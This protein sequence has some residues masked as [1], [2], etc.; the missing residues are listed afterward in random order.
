MRISERNA[1]WWAQHHSIPQAIEWQAIVY[2]QLR[3]IPLMPESYSLAPENSKFQYELRQKN[4]G[5]GVGG[6]RR[7]LQREVDEIHV[8]TIR[9]GSQRALRQEDLSLEE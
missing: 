3:T 1:V 4:V 7:F 2:Q 8:L 5:L 6:Y 9:R